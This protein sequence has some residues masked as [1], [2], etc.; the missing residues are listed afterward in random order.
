MAKDK[1]GDVEMA[2]APPSGKKD[3][4]AEMTEPPASPEEKLAET[5]KADVKLIQTALQEQEYKNLMKLNRRIIEVRKVMDGAVIA[6]FLS[7]SDAS[8]YKEALLP[9]LPAPWT[10]PEKPDTDATTATT[11]AE[12]MVYEA[13]VWFGLL[14]LIYLLDLKK[15]DGAKVASDF[16]IA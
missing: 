11:K 4:D 9:L 12:P 14:T 10:P 7:I 15:L 13:T 3:E 6:H 5:L 1:D 2:D 8:A 16:L